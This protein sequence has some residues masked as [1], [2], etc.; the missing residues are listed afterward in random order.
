MTSFYSN[1]G[2]EGTMNTRRKRSVDEDEDFEE[3]ADGS[4]G[5]TST[6][7]VYNRYTVHID[8]PI[9][10]ANYYRNVTN[11][12][13]NS[14]EGDFV[15]FEISSPG[16]Y[17]NGVIALLSSMQ[18]SDSTKVAWINGECHSAASMLAL[19]CDIIYVAPYSTMLVHFIRYGSSGKGADVISHVQHVQDTAQELFRDIYKYF[20]TEEEIKLCI[21]G[22]EMY[23]DSDEIQK[24]LK[25]R[26]ELQ[27]ASETKEVSKDKPKRKPKAKVVTDTTV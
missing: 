13:A 15:E 2:Q 24:R 10:P 5:F 21:D 23:M 7:K 17:L 3:I 4:L 12:I 22:K 1:G 27:E 26:I 18:K 19:S 20:L 6:Q 9:R 16:G 25:K 11:M 8:E 14:K